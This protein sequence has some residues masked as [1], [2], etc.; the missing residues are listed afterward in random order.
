MITNYDN[1]AVLNSL[2]SSQ[3]SY[4]FQKRVGTGVGGYDE[5][6]EMMT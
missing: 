5:E 1:N 6:D 4:A 2:L 3:V